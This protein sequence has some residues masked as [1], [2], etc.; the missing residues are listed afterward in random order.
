[1]LVPHIC[2]PLADVGKSYTLAMPYG[3]KRYHQSKQSHFITFSCYQRLPKL[4]DGRLRGIFLQCLERARRRYRFR[5]FGYVVMP[6]HVH[7]LISEPDVETLATTIQALKVSFAR[8]CESL[9][10]DEA[11]AFWQKRY[12]DHNVRTHQSFVGK[13][14]YIHR[15]PVKRGLCTTPEEWRSSSFRHYATGEIGVV[16]VE[17]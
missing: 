13:L 8:C 17:S 1:V 4:A 12:Y 11:G 16:E 9:R 10:A 7:L 14:C 3:L 6:E 2:P 15:N 5:V